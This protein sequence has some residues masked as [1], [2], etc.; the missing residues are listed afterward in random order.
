VGC[1]DL[2]GLFFFV[3]FFSFVSFLFFP[4]GFKNRKMDKKK[5]YTETAEKAWIEQRLP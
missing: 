5:G 4:L 3:S 1:V 2:W